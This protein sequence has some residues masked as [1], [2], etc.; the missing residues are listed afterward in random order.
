M[1]LQKTALALLVGWYAANAAAYSE[2]GQTGNTKSWESTEYLKD[3][4]LTSMNASTAYALG[5]NGSGMKIGVMFGNPE[6]TTG[7]NALKFYASQRIDIRRIGQIKVGDDIIGNRTKIKVV[8][9]KIAPPFRVAEFDIMYN[10]GISKTGDILDLAATHGIVEKSGAFYKYNGET[11]GQGR[12]K[13]KNYLK[14][15]PEV[16]AE[17]D[18]KVRDK[19][20][21]AES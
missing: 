21:E 19:V 9:N 20:K 10:E 13:T 1:K 2:Q 11:I 16:L 15:N 8:K 5:F 7:G 14:E 17:I 6:T 12:D 18:Q 3:W 4:G